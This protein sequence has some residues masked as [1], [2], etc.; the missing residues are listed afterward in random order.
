MWGCGVGVRWGFVGEG[1]RCGFKVCWICYARVGLWVWVWVS[2]CWIC[3]ACVVVQH[4]AVCCSVLQ[5]VAVILL[6]S[7]ALCTLFYSGA[8]WWIFFFLCVY[9]MYTRVDAMQGA[10]EGGGGG[11]GS[12]GFAESIPLHS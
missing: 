7:A 9:N 3:P 12:R 11:W 6:K 10:G 4:G 5:S 8:V 1:C 2:V